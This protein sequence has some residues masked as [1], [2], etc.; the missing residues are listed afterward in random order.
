MNRVAQPVPAASCGSVPLPA[1]TPGGTPG[2][3]AGGDARATAQAGSW[4]RCAISKLWRLSM[5]RPTRREVLECGG[6]RGT[7]LT[8]LFLAY[9]FPKPKRCVPPTLTHRTPKRGR[10]CAG[11][12]ALM[13]V[14]CWRSNLPMNL[15]AALTHARSRWIYQPS[16]CHPRAATGDRSRSAGARAVPRPQHSRLPGKK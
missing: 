4:L 11:F 12:M 9:G 2:E 7:G 15:V 16:L 3:L 6:W 8:P 1:R 5:N 10:A 13:R 14:H